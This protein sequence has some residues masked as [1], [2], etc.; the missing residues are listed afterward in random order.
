MNLH[1]KLAAG[2]CALVAG[3][4][5]STF[6]Q[7]QAWPN[8]PVKVVVPAAAGGG[9][10]MVA[11]ITTEKLSAAFG[12]QFIAENRVGAGGRTGTAYTA[13][14]PADGY[15]LL[16]G[17]AGT[18]ILPVVLYPDLPYSTLRDFAPVSLL[19]STS[20]LMVVNPK[21]PAK[22]LREFVALAKAKPGTL[23]YATTGIGSPAHL[24]NELFDI[25]AGIQTTHVPY[26]GSP[27][28]LTSVVQGETQFMFANLLSGVP[29]IR[30]GKLTALGV[31]SLQRS[32]IFP[33]IPTVIEG[34]V[35]DFTLQQFFSLWAVAGTPKDIIQ[36]LNTEVVA[37]L[38]SAETKARFAADGSE[39]SVGTP[40][41]LY[42]LTAEET[43]KWGKLI[44][45]KGIK[46]E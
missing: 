9:I 34:G 17:T 21:V 33:D 32:S 43:A 42:R 14:Q 36:R 45:E 11:R 41:A 39:V 8:K 46:G 12:Q 26:K 22:T 35:K 20:S 38:P 44:K 3:L 5:L 19:A 29:L 15:T 4:P 37:R 23:N 28:G 7:A 30:S 16:A 25:L 18:T 6:A 10:D 13:K 27:E 1:S 40:E 24:G 2:L 31:T